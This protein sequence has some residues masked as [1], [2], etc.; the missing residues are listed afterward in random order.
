MN[1][2]V[3]GKTPF[4][5]RLPGSGEPP[6]ELQK[7]VSRFCNEQLLPQLEACFDRLAGAEES[8]VIERLEISL[9]RVSGKDWEQRLLGELLEA[10]EQ[11][12][13]KR[14]EEEDDGQRIERR[15]AA[16]S[17]FDQWLHFL[18]NGWLPV[19]AGSFSES[20]MQAAVLETVAGQSFAVERLRRLLAERK[21][22]LR[23]LVLQHEPRFLRLLGEAISARQLGRL[24]AL[25]DEAAAALD[26]HFSEG[27]KAA[28]LAKLPARNAPF[29]AAVQQFFWEMAFEKFILP[30]VALDAEAAWEA[31]A[32]R[33]FEPSLAP[34]VAARL[35]SEL[36]FSPEKWKAL[37]PAMATWL[38]K[39]A[40]PTPTG[41]AEKATETTERRTTE[42]L[43]ELAP[44]TE[45]P[46][47][48]E[49]PSAL[50]PTEKEATAKAVQ[51]EKSPSEKPSAELPDDGALVA[52]GASQLNEI[53]AKT[54]KEMPLPNGEA[55][56]KEDAARPADNLEEK[57]Q[58]LASQ[59]LAAG[60][61]AVERERETP[62]ADQPLADT[63]HPFR[64]PS[65]KRHW[66]V[67]DAGVVI[68]HSFLPAF[69]K[70]A[71]L[72]DERRQFQSEEARERAVH[73]LHFLACGREQAPE[74]ELL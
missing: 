33:L 16:F 71:G 35:H 49:T 64:A 66:Y 42:S 18:E 34:A 12:I 8:I 4:E 47:G 32:D 72:L 57:Q 58:T 45:K 51:P 61:A 43:P 3:I 52:E 36:S 29:Q 13:E 62:P 30:G 11:A 53:Q 67:Q 69:F 65:E 48:I 7:R 22:A 56:L 39:T 20:E 24:S 6:L 21:T 19:H 60:V 63:P 23:R 15:P 26:A 25:A 14:L 2:H 59:P 37:L 17:R 5:M 41:I 1:R 74:H 50:E 10:I 28:A 40:S 44:A 68:L 46:A 27:E 55:A 70:A 31:I 38:E 73:L 54:G 9:D